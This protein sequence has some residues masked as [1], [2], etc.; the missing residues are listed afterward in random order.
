MKQTYVYFQPEYVSQFKCNGQACSAHC[1]RRWLITIDKK[2]YKKY[3]HIKP[4]TAANEITK[5]LYK[6]ERRNCYAVKLDKTGSCPL[7]TEDNWCMIQK[8]YGEEFLSETCV[9]YPRKTRCLGDF[10]ERALTLTCPEVATLVLNQIEPLAFEYR[11][12]S[13]KVHSN[14][15]RIGIDF[16]LLYDQKK[17]LPYIVTIQTAAIS[18]L[19]ERTLT[20]D[21]RLVVLGFFLDKL[22]ELIA[23]DKLNEIENLAAF[24]MSE[25]FLA[26]DAPKLAESISQNSS[27]HMKIMLGIFENLYGDKANFTNQDQKLVNAVIDALEMRVDENNQLSLRTIVGKYN[28]QEKARK[29]FVSYYSTVFENYLVNEF[30]MNIVPFQ[31]NGSIINDYGIFLATYKMLELISFSFAV[32]M[33]KDNPDK[34][35]KLDQII[36]IAIISIFA[37]KIDHNKTYLEKIA[38][39]LKDKN[40]MIEILQTL[41]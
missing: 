38:D 9:T 7:L 30:F 5:H 22:D 25:K 36:L 41:I 10:F 16:K 17:L 11:E 27:E 34:N 13:E 31:F 37:N 23:D 12:V 3:S 15:G 29:N 2:T 33:F 28:A 32:S 19:Q 35:F 14:L 20:I 4:K 6:D 24:Y 8:K 18:I 40:D 1:C 26:E 39:Y 21:S